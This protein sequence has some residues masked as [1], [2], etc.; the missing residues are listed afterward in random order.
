MR[1]N[2]KGGI[3]ME[4]AS[5]NTI[6]GAKKEF[7]NVISGNKGAGIRISGTNSTLNE[8]FGNHIGIGEIGLLILANEEL[9][10]LDRKLS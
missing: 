6:G 7:K 1:P 3:F 9:G 5:K 4:G 10:S 8:I 2:G